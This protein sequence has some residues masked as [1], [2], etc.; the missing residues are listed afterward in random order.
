MF[1]C[2]FGSAATLFENTQELVPAAIAVAANCIKRRL[3]ISIPE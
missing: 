2:F 3:F 1:G